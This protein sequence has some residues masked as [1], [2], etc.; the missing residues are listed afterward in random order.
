MFEL[1]AEVI[2]N[3]DAIE[4]DRPFTYK[5]KEE[6]LDIIEVGH[7]VKVPFGVKNKPTEAF[8]LGLKCEGIEN[9]KKIK[10]ISSILD[11]IPILTRDDLRL[12]DFLRENYLCKYID[13]IRTIIPSGLS[14]GIKN[15]KKTVIVFNKELDGMFKDKDNYVKIVNLIKE[16]NGEL[17]KSEIIND[18]SLSS[19]SL[20]KLIENGYLLTEDRVV[21]RYN[22]RS[23][24]EESKN[25]LNDE[26]K[27][28]FNKILNS[29]KKGFL[30][31]GVTGSGKTEVYMNLVGET[32]K[33]GK[34]AIV[35]VPEIS[36]TPQMIER[37]K[38][39]FGKNV[40]LFHSKLSQGER[41]DEWYRIKKGEARLVVGARSAIFL[42]LD[43]LGIIIIDEEHEN[44]YKSE[45]NPKYSTKEVAKFLSEIKGCKYILGS[46][47]PSIETYYEALNGKLELVEIKNRVSNRPLPQMEIVDMREELKSRN[48]SLLSRSLYNEMKETL[49]RKEQIILFLNRRGFSSFV[50]CRSC[51]YVFK[52]PECDLSMTYHKNGYLICHYCGR[53]QREQKVCP[54][55]GSKYVKFFGA[56]TQRVEEEV[57]KYFPKA[58]VMRMDVDTTR[59]KD[60]HENIYNAFKSGEGDI[61]IGTQMVSKGLDFKNVT[62]VGVLAADISLNIPDYRSS[63]RTYQIIT[64]VAGRAGRGEKKGKVVI[65]TY[66]PNSLS[67]QYAIENNYNDLYNEEIKVRKIMNYPPFS[68]IF[69]INSI[70]KDEGKLK[71]FM[72]KVGESLRKLL[73]SREDIQI[74]GPVPCIITKLKDNYRWQI[75][76]KGNLDNNLKLK[77]KDIL[78]EL[79]KS[80]YNE[81]R[82]SMDINPNNMT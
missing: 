19:Y 57:K 64:Q 9:V 74:L 17:T 63:E 45:Q 72:N 69:L 68:T 12:I 3:S 82:I 48:L 8:V 77:I 18:Y 40:A 81:I 38:G 66:T 53:A 52:C 16:K 79:N 46:A 49:E 54:E 28:A 1:Y 35:L 27:N 24:I 13:A 2:I 7:R 23:Y 58:R 75:I 37:F 6:L 10:Y 30:L 59:S 44:T 20:N 14:K 67:L 42:P 50:S 26:Q 36:L 76:I 31:K 15:K 41:F 65:Q 61:L 70:S 22:T 5:V 25:V 34:S 78:Y 4:I 80:V 29:D 60:S 55:C 51:G 32:L 71:E 56:G 39:R 11:D 43:N 33:E 21:Y 73:D 47:T 62:L